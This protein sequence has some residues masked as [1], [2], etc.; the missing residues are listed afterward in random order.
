MNKI[1][2]NIHVCD[3]TAWLDEVS[4][5]M[6]IDLWEKVSAKLRLKYIFRQYDEESCYCLSTIV[7]YRWAMNYN[8]WIIIFKGNSPVARFITIWSLK[9]KRSWWKCLMIDFNKG[10]IFYILVRIA[11]S[12][13]NEL[14][15]SFSELFTYKIIYFIKRDIFIINEHKTFLF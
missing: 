8:T 6:G 15:V 7:D 11:Q 10:K 13:E 3:H 2:Q 12:K 9:L 4:I 1:R 5:H 14:K